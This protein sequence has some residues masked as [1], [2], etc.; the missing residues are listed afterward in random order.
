M[1]TSRFFF[2][3]YHCFCHLFSWKWLQRCSLRWWLI[4]YQGSEE[5]KK[6][7]NLSFGLFPV[8]AIKMS[9]NVHT[10]MLAKMWLGARSLHRSGMTKAFFLSSNSTFELK[11][12]RNNNFFSKMCC[13]AVGFTLSFRFIVRILSFQLWLRKLLGELLVC[14][15]FEARVMVK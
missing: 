11:R 8:F 2:Y 7:N 3:G 13:Y 9:L 10:K 5:R 14:L 1:S 4:G 6:I 12:G 15:L